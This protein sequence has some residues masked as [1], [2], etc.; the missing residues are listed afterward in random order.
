MK[1]IEPDVLLELPKSQILA[2]L[3]VVM[4]KHAAGPFLAYLKTLVE[5]VDSEHGFFIRPER[6]YRLLVGLDD[7]ITKLRMSRFNPSEIEE[8][9][10]LMPQVLDEL[11][12]IQN[13]LAERFTFRIYCLNPTLRHHPMDHLAPEGS[14]V[15]ASPAQAS[16]L[17]LQIAH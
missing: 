12:R 5:A 14:F 8:I 16:N 9:L 2:A 3:N 17:P 7:D 1:M 15:P 11:L 4:R 10:E 13:R 6:F